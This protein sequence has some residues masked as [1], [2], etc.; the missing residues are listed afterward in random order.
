MYKSYQ[1]QL[2]LVHA[3]ALFAGAL[4]LDDLIT[5]VSMF[6]LRSSAFGIQSVNYLDLIPWFLIVQI[7]VLLIPKAVSIIILFV[8]NNSYYDLKVIDYDLL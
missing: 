7:Y 1:F 8:Y 5:N 6:Y 2:V 3:Q 4:A